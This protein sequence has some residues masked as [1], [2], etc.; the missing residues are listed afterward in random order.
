MDIHPGDSIQA[1]V[2]AHPEGTAFLIKAGVHRRQSVRPKSGMTFVGDHTFTPSGAASVD[3]ARSDDRAG[4]AGVEAAPARPAPVGDRLIVGVVGGGDDAAEHEVAAG[5]RHQDVGVLAEPANASE[6]GDLAVDDRVVVGEHD[7]SAADSFGL[8][9]GTGNVH[10]TEGPRNAVASG[11]VVAFAQDLRAAAG[12]G[13]RA[14]ILA[15]SGRLELAL[16][17]QQAALQRQPSRMVR[18]ERSGASVMR[19]RW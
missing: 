10:G 3:D 8:V 11:L 13:N 6:M 2:N 1:A 12:H 14:L 19:R 7:R 18:A 15:A 4:G 17:D 9:R 16:E 5:T